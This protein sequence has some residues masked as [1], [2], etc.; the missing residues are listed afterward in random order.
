MMRRGYRIF[1]A[2]LILIIIFGI[3]GTVMSKENAKLRAEQNRY[4]AAMEAEYRE[5]TQELLEREGYRNCGINL[6][7]IAYE[8]GRREY[9][10][11]LHHRKLDRLSAAERAVLQ[12]RLTETEFQEEACSFRYEL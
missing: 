8:D 3:K 5:K 1:T 10:L 2:V 7:W 11:L 12:S 6:T 9:T 4:Y